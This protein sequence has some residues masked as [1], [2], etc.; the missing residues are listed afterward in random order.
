MRTELSEPFSE[1]PALDACWD[2]IGVQGD[3]SCPKLTE[4]IHCRN[5]PVFA[6]AGQQ[7]FQRAAPPEYLEEWTRQIADAG[8]AAATE[9]V[10]LVIFRVGPEW[11]AL[12]AH[13]VI[14]IVDPRPIHRV[15]HRTNRLFLG[16]A[17]IRG[18]LELC[19]SLRELLGIEAPAAV[20]KDAA[21]SQRLIVAEHNQS[22][23][24]FPVDEVEGVHRV[25]VNEMKGL[26]HTVE[27]SPR[28]YSRAIVSR[29]EKRIGVIAETRL[30][31]ALERTLQ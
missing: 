15:P 5:C 28:Y 9:T 20:E 11:L 13:D 22:C 3:R 23:W 2:R 26:P 18:E 7:L 17:N 30:F 10:S 29:D 19:I 31:P 25:P 4:A 8:E 12:D 24:V 21:A 27:K 14:E 1:R 6:D 16:I